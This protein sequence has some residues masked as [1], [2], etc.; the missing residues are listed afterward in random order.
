LEISR[1]NRLDYDLADFST[2]DRKYVRRLIDDL[3]KGKVENEINC[4]TNNREAD[5]AIYISD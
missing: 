2:A 1:G 4:H 5:K 3:P